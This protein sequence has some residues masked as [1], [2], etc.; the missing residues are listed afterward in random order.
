MNFG[1]VVAGYVLSD[2]LHFIDDQKQIDSVMFGI[3]IN[4]VRHDYLYELD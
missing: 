3:V 2:I 4:K 1:E